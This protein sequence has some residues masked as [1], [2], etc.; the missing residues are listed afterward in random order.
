MLLLENATAKNIVAGGGAVAVV[1][2]ALVGLWVL[3]GSL[4]LALD[5]RSVWISR[6]A[7]LP[8]LWGLDD[9]GAVRIELCLFWLD[10]AA[11]FAAGLLPGQTSGG[12]L[13]GGSGG[14][15]RG[16][17]AESRTTGSV[18][19]NLVHVNIGTAEVEVVLVCRRCWVA[20]QAR[21]R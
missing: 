4:P 12:Q 1:G 13:D 8:N 16:H 7:G 20:T 2:V 21:R 14:L 15:R 11:G 5:G 6:L 17:N 9:G 18:D 3:R 19:N 10:G